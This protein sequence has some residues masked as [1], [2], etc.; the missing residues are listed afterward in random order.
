MIVAQARRSLA[1]TSYQQWID[2]I[3]DDQKGEERR[4]RCSLAAREER[5]NRGAGE[6][7]DDPPDE[8]VQLAGA[9]STSC[10]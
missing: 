8:L 3:A 2:A 5:E 1:R 4:G 7:R 10:C 9:R 6:Q